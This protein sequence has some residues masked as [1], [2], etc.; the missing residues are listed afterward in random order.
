MT[1]RW[2]PG[3][4]TTGQAWDIFQNSCPAPDHFQ[5]KDLHSGRANF[6][7]HLADTEGVGSHLFSG[8]PLAQPYWGIFKPPLWINWYSGPISWAQPDYCLYCLSMIPLVIIRK[9]F[10][11][12]VIC[13]GERS[14]TLLHSSAQAGAQ[15]GA[16]FM[17]AQTQMNTTRGNTEVTTQLSFPKHFPKGITKL[18]LMQ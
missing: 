11:S 10:P 6:N 3:E 4:N 13:P 18:H 9:A 16:R 2:C 8:T 1:W 5:F 17:V 15:T 12:R 7:V 14:L